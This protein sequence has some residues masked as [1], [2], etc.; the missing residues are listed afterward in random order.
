MD[1]ET[2]LVAEDNSVCGQQAEWKVKVRDRIGTTVVTPM[3]NKHRS[4]Y[5]RKAAELR[6]KK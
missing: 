6:V 5:N 1:T 4:E 3:C 2:C